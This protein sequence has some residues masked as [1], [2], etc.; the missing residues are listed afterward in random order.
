MKGCVESSA[1]LRSNKIYLKNPKNYHIFYNLK[2]LGLKNVFL[3][4]LTAAAM[5]RF[6]ALF[7]LTLTLCLSIGATQ[8]NETATSEPARDGK[9]IKFLSLN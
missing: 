5:R 1:H 3:I 8:K 2:I 4:L 6:E 9:G 7:L